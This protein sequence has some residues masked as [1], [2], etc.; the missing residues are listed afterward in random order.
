MNT[1][2]DFYLTLAMIGTLAAA[3]LIIAF[4]VNYFDI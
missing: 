4:I 1:W 2:P 3:A